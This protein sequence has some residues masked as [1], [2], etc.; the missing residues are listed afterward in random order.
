MLGPSSRSTVA[1]MMIL[2]SSGFLGQAAGQP[3]PKEVKKI[4]TIL[5]AKPLESDPKDDEA[6]KLL[7]ALYNERLAIAGQHYRLYAGHH[8]NDCEV[9]LD[10]AR[11]LRSV[12]LEI[13]ATSAE[14]T[15]LLE[16]M[17]ELSARI[18]S[19]VGAREALFKR[20][21]NQDT[22]LLQLQKIRAFELET[23]IELAKLKK[24][25]K[26]ENEKGPK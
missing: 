5:T 21:G 20:P 4:P 24:T 9:V 3:D 1:F 15:H 17:L 12:G 7:K 22:Y 10:Q 8:S 18:N 16:Q 2:A 19:F 6:Q 13:A 26:A 23:R 25:L 14:K 11:R